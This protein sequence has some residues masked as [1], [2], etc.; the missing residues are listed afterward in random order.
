MYNYIDGDPYKLEILNFKYRGICVRCRDIRLESDKIKWFNLDTIN[1]I[2]RGLG[3][4][5]IIGVSM[6]TLRDYLIKGTMMEIII[7]IPPN[8][9]NKITIFD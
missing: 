9:F 6:L 7:E 3:C 4:N 1:L 5:P 8:K 2:I